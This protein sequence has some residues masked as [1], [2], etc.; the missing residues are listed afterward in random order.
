MEPN[1]V[2]F[3]SRTTATHTV[4]VGCGNP[5]K[6][7]GSLSL[8]LSQGSASSA[9]SAEHAIRHRQANLHAH[10]RILHGQRGRQHRGLGRSSGNI[11]R[12]WP[13]LAVFRGSKVVQCVSTLGS[14]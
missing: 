9:T 11:E 1:R 4:T 5:L 13:Q 10:R 14:V 7:T 3:F 12:D 6:P 8:L 2:W